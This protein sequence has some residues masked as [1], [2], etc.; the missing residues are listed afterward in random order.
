MPSTVHDAY[1]CHHG[2]AL[3]QDKMSYLKRNTRLYMDA[4]KIAQPT[5]RFEEV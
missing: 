2:R 4:H 3:S 5:S 1:L